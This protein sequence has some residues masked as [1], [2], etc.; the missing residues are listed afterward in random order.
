MAWSVVANLVSP[1]S[2]P[3]GD[4]LYKGFVGLETLWPGCIRASGD[5]SGG[6]FSLSGSVFTFGHNNAPAANNICSPNAWI[7]IAP[8]DDSYFICFKRGG[9]YSYSWNMFFSRNPFTGGSPS[10][11]V[12]PT[13]V[14]EVPVSGELSGI[15]GSSSPNYYGGLTHVIVGGVDERYS[16]MVL[17][18]HLG[19]HHLD[20]GGSSYLSTGGFGVDMV[21]RPSFIGGGD[22]PVIL[23]PDSANWGN[24]ASG[25]W[26]DTRGWIANAGAFAHLT[27]SDTYF[28]SVGLLQPSRSSSRIWQHRFRSG[29]RT[30]Y[31]YR[32]VWYSRGTSGNEW[33]NNQL[34]GAS[35]LLRVFPQTAQSTSTAAATSEGRAGM[36]LTNDYQW[37][38]PGSGGH[39]A[40]PWDGVT[41]L[42]VAGA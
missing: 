41:E 6:N 26:G 32:P 33:A 8:P 22:T 28:T 40:F 10:A 36:A 38:L 21:E 14:G 30:A 25:G 34:V 18:G 15:L 17:N 24:L 13:S 27:P 2:T 12:R 19:I 35:R 37:F 3:A 39:I 42:L 29:G 31:A 20:S 1:S 23:F 16:F 4:I 11:T 9:F 7:V 5:G